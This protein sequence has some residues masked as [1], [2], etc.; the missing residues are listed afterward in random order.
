MLAAA[1]A[2]LVWA[3]SPWRTPTSRSGRRACRRARQ[4]RPRNRPAPLGQRGAD[5]ALL[6]RR[7]ARGQA[8]A[9]PRRAARAPP[10]RD[11]GAGR[12][13]RDRPC[14]SR[15]TWRSTPAAPART[16]GARR[17]RPTPRSRSASLAL[18]TPRA[19]TRLRVFL[20]TLAVVD[21]LRA[22]L[23]IAIVYTEHVS[24]VALAIASGCSRLLLGAA[25]RAASARAAAVG[26]GRRSAIW[27]AMFKSGIDPVDLRARRRPGHERLPARRARTSSARPT[28][29]RSFREQPT[30]EL[31]ALGAA[32]PAV[33]DLAQRAPPVPPAP[34]DEL[35]DRAA[36]RARQR[37]R[38]HRPAAL[39]GDAI[40]LADHARD[41]RRLRRR[42]AD[43]HRRRARGS[44][45]AR[46]CTGRA[47]RSAARCWS[48]AA[49]V[50]GI[51]FTVS[52][53]I[54]S[55]AFT[56][57]RAR[58]G[59][60]RRARRRRARAAARPWLVLAVDPT[61][62]RRA[63]ARG[64]SARTAEDILDLAEDVDPGA[65]PHPRPRRRAGHAASST[66]T[67]SAR[68]AARPSR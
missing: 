41:P 53:L 15:S 12:A 51:G 34:V 65:R 25:L 10:R 32:G 57:Q 52:L 36:V 29:A 54:S 60:A 64:R 47:R 68:T 7:R 66:A 40:A 33:G 44:R 35:R 63:C 42:Q 8:R 17:C 5:D 58:R 45:R 18:L 62:A 67:S 59:E 55:L 13:R 48:P 27:V 56:G 20:L 43:R 14:R 37:G 61:P 24:V 1:I 19:A 26:R 11:P 3:N 28:L 4:P 50:A 30:P 49:R 16:A 9:R 2:A 22:L 23:V 6:P 21:D 46:R 38:P 31:A 39:L